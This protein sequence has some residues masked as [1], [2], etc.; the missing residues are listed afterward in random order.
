[1]KARTVWRPRHARVVAPDMNVTPLVDVVLV[2]LIIFMVVA[3]RLEQDIPVTLP[4]IFHPDPEGTV[5]APP[6]VVTLRDPGEYFLD[7]RA[8]DLD[9]IATALAVA[10][11]AMP[12]RRLELRGDAKLKYREIRTIYQRAHQ[13][14]FPGISFLVTQKSARATT[15]A[16]TGME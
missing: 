9:G 16:A 14:G 7:G 12:H 4:G 2:L 6:L 5:S 3:P 1:M 13:I 11:A 8:H 15:T 10:H